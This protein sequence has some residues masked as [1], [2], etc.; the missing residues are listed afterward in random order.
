MNAHEEDKK[1]VEAAVT[2]FP[3]T[4]GLKAFPGD[5]FRVSAQSSYMS[6]GNVMLYTEIHK[7]DGWLSFAKGTVSELKGEVVVL[8]SGMRKEEEIKERLA[9]VLSELAAI[10]ERDDEY[11]EFDTERSTLQ[12]VLGAELGN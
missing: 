9:I 6:S 7:G 1:K 3:A 5:V 10:D 12:W 11:A 8:P 4:F 2:Q